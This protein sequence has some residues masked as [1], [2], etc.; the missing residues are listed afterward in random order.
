MYPS[1]QLPFWGIVIKANRLDGDP[2]F[3]GFPPFLR[4][5]LTHPQGRSQRRA[6]KPQDLSELIEDNPM[7]ERQKQS[8]PEG[9]INSPVPMKNCYGGEVRGTRVKE[10]G[11]CSA[12]V[13]RTKVSKAASGSLCRT[14]AVCP[15]DLNCAE[16]RVLRS[17]RPWKYQMDPEERNES[18]GPKAF[19]NLSQFDRPG[20]P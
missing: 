19:A 15:L 11:D 13:L 14:W 4:H 6:L 7:R 16:T 5:A 9:L 18:Q 2:F 10:M 1:L 3:G 12:L 20:N 17:A 8:R